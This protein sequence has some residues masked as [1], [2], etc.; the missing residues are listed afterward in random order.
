MYLHVILQLL[1]P[2]INRCRVAKLAWLSTLSLLSST[3]LEKL[4]SGALIYIAIS[5]PLIQRT[6]VYYIIT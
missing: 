5:L 2:N 4:V 3:G 1:M 6:V